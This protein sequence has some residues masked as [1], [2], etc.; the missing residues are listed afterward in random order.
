MMSEGSKAERFEAVSKWTATW[1]GFVGGNIASLVKWGSEIPLPPRTP[2]RVSPPAQM[3][4]DCGIEVDRIAYFYSQH[5]VN[6][7][8]LLVHHV[9]SIFFAIAYCL[10]CRRY[11][12]FSM[13]QGVAF[14]LM[15]T[16]GFHGIILPMGHWSPTFWHLPFDEL[17]SETSGHI[18]WAWV[19]E[20]S[21]R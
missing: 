16:I 19:I 1:A 10:S 2:D 4:R 12:R 14:G 5:I 9:F 21:R 3:L 13:W 11:P 15:V 18:L 20:I 17:F 8:V 6:L 7:G